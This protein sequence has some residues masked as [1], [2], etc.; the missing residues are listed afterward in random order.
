MARS[1]RRRKGKSKGNQPLI[2][3]I[4]AV[5]A[6]IVGALFFKS[7]SSG[8]DMADENF[9]TEQYLR[10]GSAAVGN[11]YRIKANVA[12]VNSHG[13]SRI[14]QILTDDNRRLGLYVPSG[15][16]LQANVRKGLDYVFTVK[17]CN[18]TT[19]DGTPVKGVLVVTQAEAK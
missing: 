6:V 13:S 19:S 12:E 2:I 4:V 8:T 16:Q 15:T 14:I 18:G 5:A 9:S 3:T 17:G 11:T 7:K 1:S 10:R